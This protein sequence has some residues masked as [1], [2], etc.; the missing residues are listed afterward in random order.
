[1]PEPLPTEAGALRMRLGNPDFVRREM[2]TEL[3][4]YDAP[5]CSVFFFMQQQDGM[6]RL[7]YTET[8]PRGTNTAADPACLSALQDHMAA[9][10]GIMN[11]PVAP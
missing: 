10:P 3:W 9:A 8:L 1:M 7:R 2:G 6:L 5:R 11:A 4:R